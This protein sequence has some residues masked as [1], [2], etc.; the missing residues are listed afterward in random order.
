M[1]LYYIT[2]RRQFSGTDAEQRRALLTRIGEAARAGV[3]YIQLREK[4]LPAAA[5]EQLARAAMQVVREGGG[6][7]RL[8]VNSRTDVALAA[9][10]DGVHLT[11][12]DIS[13]S[14]AR[15]IADRASRG[16]SAPARTLLVAV[17]CH[18]VDEVRMAESHGADFVVLA[19]IF[20][21]PGTT[22]P[23][24]GLTT[25]AS[26]AAGAPA[27]PRVEAGENRARVSILAL[28]GVTTDNACDCV[29]AGAAGVA[30]V[31]LFQQGDVADTVRRLRELRKSEPPDVRLENRDLR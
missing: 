17:S 30:G 22:S 29:R 9:G 21:K 28:G 4:D 11:S 25:L 6:A 16:S 10:A 20:E 5:L 2:D 27:M 8:L 13:A 12:T 26:A 18:S 24:I 7:A 14:D 31:R 3:D 23:S 15:A 1:L 19:P